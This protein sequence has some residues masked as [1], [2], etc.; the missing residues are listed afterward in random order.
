MTMQ[1]ARDALHA[2]GWTLGL[3]RHAR[4]NCW[5]ATAVSREHKPSIK[6]TYSTRAKVLDYLVDVVRR[7]V[8]KEREADG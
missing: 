6:V 7:K 3:V 2:F 8:M 5:E 1:E 4:P